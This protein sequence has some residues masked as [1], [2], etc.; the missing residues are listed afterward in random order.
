MKGNFWNFKPPGGIW[1]KEGRKVTR[2]A[3]INKRRARI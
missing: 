3:L 1:D 2:Y